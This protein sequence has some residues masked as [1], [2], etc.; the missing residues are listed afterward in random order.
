MPVLS[1]TQEGTIWF[2]EPQ[3]ASRI[4]SHP[5]PGP[6]VPEVPATG[7]APGFI[8]NP[9]R[10]AA[11]SS[12]WANHD[13]IVFIWNVRSEMANVSAKAARFGISVETL[14]TCV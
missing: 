9:S 10:V 12:M 13:G 11:A 4:E 3:A 7:F 14:W 5:H 2:E 1:G 6:V 8:E